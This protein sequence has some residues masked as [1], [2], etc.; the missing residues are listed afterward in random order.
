MNDQP[1]DIESALKDLQNI[2][3]EN[4]EQEYNNL[5]LLYQEEIPQADSIA[6]RESAAR[7]ASDIRSQQVL[8]EKMIEWAKGPQQ[9]ETGKTC[10]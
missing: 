7:R 8:C 6:Y 2:A 9:K 3:R 10:V 1:F 5:R 4:W